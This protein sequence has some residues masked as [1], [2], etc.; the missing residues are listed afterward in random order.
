VFLADF[1]PPFPTGAGKNSFYGIFSL[2]ELKTYFSVFFKFLIAAGKEIFQISSVSDTLKNHTMV[3]LYI[4]VTF[5]YLTYIVYKP[6]KLPLVWNF[7]L[8]K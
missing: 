6:E 3:I 1:R 5:L 2:E 7:L 4:V 8:K